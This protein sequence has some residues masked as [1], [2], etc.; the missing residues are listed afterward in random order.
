MTRTE[1]IE[2]VK[3]LEEVLGSAKCAY[4][5]NLQGMTVE[6]VSELRKR[7]RE[8]K[9]RIEVTKNTLLR[10]AIGSTGNEVLLPHLAGPTALVTSAE[11]EVAPARILIGFQKEFKA[12]E[13]R[14][15]VIDGKLIDNDEVKEISTLPSKDVLLG[16]FMRTVQSPLSDL[17]SQLASPMRD[18]AGA[19]QALAEQKGGVS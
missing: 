10:R 15:G 12:P 2:K 18:L 14:A 8:E 5:A 17:V 13:V 4:L 1:K 16:M 3:N 9:V 6:V 11:D 7:C 19:L